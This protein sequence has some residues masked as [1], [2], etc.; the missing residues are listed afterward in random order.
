MQPLTEQQFCLWTGEFG[1]ELSKFT[2]TTIFEDD[3]L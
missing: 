3:I 2:S 1:N